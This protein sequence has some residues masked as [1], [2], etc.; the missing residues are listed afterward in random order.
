MLIRRGLEDLIL[1][2]NWGNGGRLIPQIPILKFLKNIS[3]WGVHL[4]RRNVLLGWRPCCTSYRLH[5]TSYPP[6]CFVHV[7]EVHHLWSKY[8][9][10]LLGQLGDTLCWSSDHCTIFPFWYLYLISRGT[11]W[12]FQLGSLQISFGVNII[13]LT[14]FFCYQLYLLDPEVKVPGIL[15]N[16]RLGWACW[17][18]LHYDWACW[19]SILWVLS[20]REWPA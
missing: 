16:D 8:L 4:I 13:P 6:V 9:I 5:P 19:A 1:L 10:L 2:M 11:R 14:F 3:Y 12:I 17:L 20:G 15:R 18:V 7:L